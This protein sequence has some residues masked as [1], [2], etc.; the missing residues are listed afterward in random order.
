MSNATLE[1]T[2]IFTALAG[3]TVGRDEAGNIYYRSS[4]TRCSGQGIIQGYYYVQG[5]VCFKCNGNGGFGPWIAEEVWNAEVARKQAQAE[6]RQEAKARKLARE[7]Q[8]NLENVLSAYGADLFEGLCDESPAFVRDILDKARRWGSISE[9]QANAVRKALAPKPAKEEQALLAPLP[10]GRVK[11][12]GKILRVKTQDSPWGTQTKI[13]V[14]NENGWKV[15]GT[16]PAGLEAGE[17][18]EVSFTATVEAKPGEA[19]FGFF[20]RP[21]A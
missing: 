9:A 10:V 1:A 13:L 21:K 8:A 16:F 17:G 6:K 12:T 14:Q 19:G 5:G 4:C 2:K 11:I 15:Y 18:D 3:D 7:A 20:S